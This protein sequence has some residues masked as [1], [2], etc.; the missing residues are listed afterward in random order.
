MKKFATLLLVMFC[1]LLTACNDFTVQKPIVEDEWGIYFSADGVTSKGMI[2]KIE[3]F[4][5]NASGELQTGAAYTIETMVDGQWKEVE[6]KTG[7]PLVWV[8]LAYGIKKN[9]VTEMKIDWTNTYGKLKPG[10][11]RTKKE[12]NDFKAPGDYETKT[13][14]VDFSV[15]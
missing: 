1:L 2:L 7:E 11:Y 6:T 13:Y 15:K 3:Q 10:D 12:I 9:D 5:G 4:G 8:M 14:Q